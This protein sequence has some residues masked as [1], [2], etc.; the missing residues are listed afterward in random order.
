MA[1]TPPP[2]TP[3]RSTTYHTHYPHTPHMSVCECTGPVSRPS[4]LPS[5][6]EVSAH[7][8]ARRPRRPVPH[9]TPGTRHTHNTHNTTAHTPHTAHHTHAHSA[10]HLACFLRVCCR[11][12]VFR[13]P[14]AMCRPAQARPSG[15]GAPRCGAPRIRGREQRPIYALQTHVTHKQHHG[16]M[17]LHMYTCCGCM[18][19]S[20][21][22]CMPHPQIIAAP[23]HRQARWGT[24]PFTGSKN[25]QE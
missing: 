4:A 25:D 22:F 5:H 11:H 7:R 13:S 3:Q 10:T 19:H 9:H 1:C 17:L 6:T 20:T 8:T 14:R 2:H 21:C 18:L 15:N 12:G 16:N 23:L 24:Q